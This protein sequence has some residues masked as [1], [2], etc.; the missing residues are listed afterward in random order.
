MLHLPRGVSQSPTEGEEM[1]CVCECMTLLKYS[2][3]QK[4][5]TIP[6]KLIAI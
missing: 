6:L 2:T 5:V 3:C 4:K 1:D